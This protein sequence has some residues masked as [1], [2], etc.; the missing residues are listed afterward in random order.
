MKVARY[1]YRGVASWGIVVDGQIHALEGELW[2][3]M[4]PGERVCALDDAKLLAPVGPHNKAL[5]LGLTYKDMY[6]EYEF[7]EGK[8]HR[9]GPAT[10]MKPSN[11]LV[12][13]MDPIVYHAVCKRLIYEAEVAI[14]IGKR[15]SRLS[16]DDAQDVIAGYTCVNDV[17]ATDFALVERPIVSTRFKICDTFCPAGPVVETEMDPA[18]IT[19]ICRVNG[20]EVQRSRTGRD[21]VWSFAELLVWV[22]GFMTLEPGDMICTGAAGTGRIEVG[23]MVEVEIPGIGV[24]VNPVA[25]P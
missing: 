12:G 3:A 22:T 11:T 7:R 8:G 21:M 15:A 24:L 9:D 18:D 25:A 17:T 16:L 20:R 4:R 2:G 6:R 23:D 14:I 5:G 1:S 13:Q 10:F 19:V